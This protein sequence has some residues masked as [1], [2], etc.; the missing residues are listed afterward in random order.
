M[1]W[2]FGGVVLSVCIVLRHMKNNPKKRVLGFLGG[3]LRALPAI[4]LALAYWVFFSSFCDVHI[5]DENKTYL[6]YNQTSISSCNEENE[7]VNHFS[8]GY[9]FVNKEMYYVYMAE[10][11]PEKIKADSFELRTTTKEPYAEK[12]IYY[13]NN[14]FLN[15]LAFPGDF[16]HILY[17]PEGTA[18]SD[19]E[20]DPEAIPQ[21]ISLSK[22]QAFG[23]F[24]SRIVN[25]L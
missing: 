16:H 13:Y 3:L 25:E 20:I 14:P 23:L 21:G 24:I 9:G 22:I 10:N 5:S 2:M 1:F 19:Y 8:L 17:F 15:L 6:L 18:V 12:Y 7:D 11:E 4:A